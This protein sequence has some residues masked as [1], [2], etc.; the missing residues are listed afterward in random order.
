MLPGSFDCINDWLDNFNKLTQSKF[1][2]SFQQ[3]RV[4]APTANMANRSC[5]SEFGTST[6][7]FI[8]S[9]FFLKLVH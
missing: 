4:S 6:S 1:I 9:A 3:S 2:V 8:N 7:Y 5:C